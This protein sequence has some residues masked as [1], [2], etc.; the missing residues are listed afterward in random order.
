MAKNKLG[1][2]GVL[3]GLAF[4]AVVLQHSIGHYYPLPETGLADGVILGIL[5]LLSKFAVPVFLFITGIVLFYNYDG[6]VQAG[7]FLRK[8]LYDIVWPYAAWSA[9]YAAE[10]HKLDFLSWEAYR[11]LGF[12][13][14]TGQASYHLWYVVMV[15][16]FY[17]LFPYLKQPLYK[18]IGRPVPALVTLLTAGAGY[19]GLMMQKGPIYQLAY[20]HQLPFLTDYFTTYMDRNAIM[21]FFY[22]IFGAV[23][24]VH[25]D[26]WRK[27][28]HRFSGFVGAVS[29]AMLA[30]LLYRVVAHFQLLPEV[31]IQYNDTFL[32]QPFMAVFLTVSL[33]ASYGCALWL[34]HNPGSMV[35]K[36]LSWIGAHSYMAYLAHAL[37]LDYSEG[38]ADWAGGG[39]TM[40]TLSLF[41]LASVL[42]VAAAVL[43]RRA[44]VWLKA[45]ARTTQALAKSSISGS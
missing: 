31:R 39:I 7:P 6:K 21:Y 26:S 24:G 2:I 45:I 8:R 1:E 23:V 20:S 43:L 22:F 3:R 17:L 29:A 13:I 4:L 33:F 35:Q 19:M 15:M 41:V 9:V 18:L 25:I 27:L 32:L 12:W 44:G 40:R 5:L 30:L 37:M 28:L 38:L 36:G 34:R 14:G 11:K 10:V 16:Q 42:S